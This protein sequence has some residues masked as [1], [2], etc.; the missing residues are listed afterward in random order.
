MNRL[1]RQGFLAA[2]AATA[3]AAVPAGSNAQ[4]TAAAV[5]QR[6]AIPQ[7]LVLS[8]GGALGA[9][10]A[11]VVDSLV[12]AAGVSDG[13]PLTPY[14]LV[15]GTSIGA[16]NAYFV[17]TGQYTKLRSLWSSISTENAV[18]L[19][20]EYAKIK[21]ESAGVFNR[22]FETFS[23]IHGLRHNETG[24]LDGDHLRTW[25]I[26]Y[27]DFSAPVVT[28]MI[29]AVTNLTQERPEYFY[30]APSHA[31]DAARGLALASVR[32]AMGSATPVREAS[33]EILVDQLRASAAVPVA[34]DPVA[35]PA[36]EGGED[37]YVDGGVT[38]N[39][40]VRI[41][42][43]LA[44]RVDAI[45][46]NPAFAPEPTRNAVD[47]VAGSF[48]TM[49]R[50]LMETSMRS[51]Y[52]ESFAL[53]ALRQL[54][55]QFSVDAARTAGITLD[56]MLAV[57]N[58]FYETSLWAMRPSKVLPVSILGFQD[59]EALASTYARGV[60]DGIAG[61]KEFTPGF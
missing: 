15:C 24:V 61:F 13:Q 22:L 43:A 54:P 45:L 11:G 17:A 14:G 26:N 1:S 7:A 23:L 46:L 4:S 20:P 30:L 49:Q 33:R 18:R 51:A 27:F 35:L 5:Q 32:L 58:A 40:P 55:Q 9:Y 37:L 21:L 57:Q 48:D 29:W 3:A 25:L 2:A 34:F 39:T 16:F 52:V 60:S 6:G 44:A 53:R 41:A 47:V 12:R 56:Q 50:R 8:G 31:T 59:G 10:E 28:P 19:K 42:T 36:P 38:A